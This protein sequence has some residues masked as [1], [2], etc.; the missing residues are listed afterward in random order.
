MFK[1]LGMK[2]TGFDVPP[3][4]VDRFTHCYSF[5]PPGGGAGG[6][7]QLR[8]SEA[9]VSE[10]VSGDASIT[11]PHVGGFRDN[12]PE[13][14]AN[15][16]YCGRPKM[17]SGTGGMVG[18]ATDYAAFCNMLLAGGVAPS[19]ERLLGVKTIVVA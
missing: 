4:K 14:N 19:G 2:D 8:E 11:F 6:G 1:P 18:T 17:I 3:E 10:V 9:D 7:I 15:Y 16:L 13:A 12:G 5:V